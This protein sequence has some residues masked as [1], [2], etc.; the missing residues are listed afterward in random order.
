MSNKRR[1]YSSHYGRRCG[2][3]GKRRFK[4][5]GAAFNRGLQIADTPACNA[6]I[7]RVYQCEFCGGWHLTS[8]PA[9]KS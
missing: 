6:E 2:M 9:R 5:H 7:L 8:K 1:I 3:T 4:S